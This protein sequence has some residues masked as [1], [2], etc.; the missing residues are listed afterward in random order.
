VHEYPATQN[1]IETV[2]RHAATLRNAAPAKDRVSV[3][4]ITLV[5]GEASGMIGESILLYFDLMAKG[6]A[7]EDAELSIETV[8]PRLRCRACGKLFLRKPFSFEC[9]CGGEGEPTEIGREFYVK[10]IEV[11]TGLCPA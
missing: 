11:E 4:K 9:E 7:C 10:D 6:T 2:L 1:I 8:K 5:I 3:K